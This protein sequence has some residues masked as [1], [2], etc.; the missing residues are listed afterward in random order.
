[1]CF[2][3]ADGLFALKVNGGWG[4]GKRQLFWPV[5]REPRNY[6]IRRN[7]FETSGFSLG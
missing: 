5:E 7:V 1:M 4:G 6:K 2:V 3:Q